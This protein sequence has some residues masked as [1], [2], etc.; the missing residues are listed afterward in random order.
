V[1]VP[2]GLYFVTLRQGIG[3]RASRTAPVVVLH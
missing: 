3:S 1:R 2:A